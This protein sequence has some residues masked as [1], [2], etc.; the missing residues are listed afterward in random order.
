MKEV[1]IIGVELARQVFQL[2]R[3]TAEGEGNHPVGTAVAQSR[4]VRRATPS[5]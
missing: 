4:I 1:S 2:D 5:P 3:A